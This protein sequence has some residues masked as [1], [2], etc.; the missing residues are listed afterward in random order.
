MT[1][2]S[3]H[4][5]NISRPAWPPDQRPRFGKSI[6]RSIPLFDQILTF[7]FCS[8]GEAE[9]SE[10]AFGLID[11]LW[12]ISGGRRAPVG[13]AVEFVEFSEP[14]FVKIGANLLAR[15]VGQGAFVS[16]QTRV[17]ATDP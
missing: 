17:L 12:K 8:L 5:R 16:T 14:G 11:Q 2:S 1:G 10:V 13:N 7:G 3:K 15:P 4:S 6:S 9:R